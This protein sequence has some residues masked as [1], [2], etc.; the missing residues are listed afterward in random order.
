MTGSV[1]LARAKGGDNNQQ[2]AFQIP[3]IRS[4][5][6]KGKAHAGG[7]EHIV[8]D[9][10]ISLGEQ[11]ERANRTFLSA[12]ER[13][14]IWGMRTALKYGAEI[15]CRDEAGRSGLMLAAHSKNENAVRFILETMQ[16]MGMKGNEI[17]SYVN[18]RGGAI[19]KTTALGHVNTVV[20]RTSPVSHGIAEV[21]RGFEAH[22]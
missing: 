11:K 17:V 2:G 9:G 8:K 18:L 5:S 16:E 20:G 19:S 3:K 12:A 14:N 4:A 21:L 7:P 10:N 15:T 13:G 22:M 6:E 1:L